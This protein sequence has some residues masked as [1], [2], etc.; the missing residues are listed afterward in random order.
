MKVEDLVKL[1]LDDLETELD[2]GSFSKTFLDS[3]LEA[4]KAGENRKGAIK[5]IEDAIEL[6]DDEPAEAEAL[7]KLAETAQQEIKGGEGKTPDQVLESLR[8]DRE[9]TPEPEPESEQSLATSGETYAVAQG[10]SIG[11]K[12][13]IK[14]DGDIVDP[15]WPEFKA[16]PKLLDSLLEKGFVVKQEPEAK[17]EPESE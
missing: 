15:T 10:L 13:G 4:E 17:Q 2:K 16:N 5:L 3:L 8:S 7:Q 1:N 14:S 12:A 11:F 6:A 9:Q